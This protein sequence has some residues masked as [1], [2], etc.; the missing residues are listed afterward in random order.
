MLSL[1]SRAAGRLTVGADMRDDW[2]TRAKGAAAMIVGGA[3][4]KLGMTFLS[5]AVG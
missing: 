2:L 1:F 3:D 5:A 4:R